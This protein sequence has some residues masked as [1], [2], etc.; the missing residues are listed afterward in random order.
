MLHDPQ[1]RTSIENRLRSLRPDTQHRWG[2][3]SVDQMLWHV[4]HGIALSVGQ[5]T[6]PP[7]K[8]PLPRP[9]MRFLVL[10]LPW[11]KGAPTL[12]Q[13]E[14]KQQYDFETERAR[15]FQLLDMFAKKKLDD[16]W[17]LDPVFG[18]VTGRF[19]SK[20]LAKHLNHHLRQ[21]GV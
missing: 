3:M 5:L 1:C 19:K 14:A 12:P 10:N 4:N 18:K 11:P 6:A 15:C 13:A 8:T 21:F 17:P 9:V 2:K 16:A 20:L 7:H